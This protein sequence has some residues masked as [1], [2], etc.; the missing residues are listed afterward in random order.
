MLCA[1]TG[2]ADCS[3][4]K[5]NTRKIVMFGVILT[6][7]LRTMVLTKDKLPASADGITKR[8]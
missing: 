7:L 3:P 6:N 5:N 2:R 4:K 8:T 1:E